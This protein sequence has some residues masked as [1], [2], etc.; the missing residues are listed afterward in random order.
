MGRVN[1][2]AQRNVIHKRSARGLVRDTQG[3]LL[4]LKWRDPKT[5]R[6]V[7]EVPG[8]SVEGKETLQEA[9]TRELR[10][11]TGYTNVKVGPAVW[12]R[13]HSFVWAE[14]EYAVEETFFLCDLLSEHRVL[15][16]RDEVEAAGFLEQRWWELHALPARDELFTPPDL[17]SRWS[18]LQKHGPKDGLLDISEDEPGLGRKVS[19]RTRLRKDAK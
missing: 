6:V 4:L 7:W 16:T 3:R 15:P 12:K 11:E 17:G 14:R 9:L 8:G 18:A 10:E 13:R 5:G 19:E 1:E 2:A